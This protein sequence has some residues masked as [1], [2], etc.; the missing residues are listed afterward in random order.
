MP[1]W[2]M[3]YITSLRSFSAQYLDLLTAPLVAPL[4]SL[5]VLLVSNCQ[6][7]RTCPNPLT[8]NGFHCPT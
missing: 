6:I 1:H 8:L 3:H 2:L 5:D 7:A 4:K